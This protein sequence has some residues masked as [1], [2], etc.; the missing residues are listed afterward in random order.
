MRMSDMLNDHFASNDLSRRYCAGKKA[1][2][3]RN[4]TDATDAAQFGSCYSG[5]WFEDLNFFKALF[6]NIIDPVD[7]YHVTTKI[8][9]FVGSCCKALCRNY[10]ELTIMMILVVEGAAWYPFA[11]FDIYVVQMGPKE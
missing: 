8:V 2:G 4:V 11:V 10:E 3:C 6:N 9:N 1:A 5:S 7:P